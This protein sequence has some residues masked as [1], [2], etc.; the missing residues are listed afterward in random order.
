MLAAL[1]APGAS[2]LVAVLLGLVVGCVVAAVHLAACSLV[3]EA[4][5]RP[6]SLRRPA[7]SLG[8]FVMAGLLLLV[9]G[10][11]TRS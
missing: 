11:A 4:R 3:D 1:G 8:L 5:G 9:V 2:G 10:G 6:V 7:W